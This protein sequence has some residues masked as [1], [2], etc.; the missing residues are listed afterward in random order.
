MNRGQIA[1]SCR[2]S[3]GLAPR[4]SMSIAFTYKDLYRPY[5]HQLRGSNTVQWLLDAARPIW[6]LPFR[7]TSWGHPQTGKR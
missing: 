5:C 2:I 7:V 6:V 4:S 1:P 3:E